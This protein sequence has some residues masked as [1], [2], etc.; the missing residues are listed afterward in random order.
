MIRSQFPG[1]TEMKNYLEWFPLVSCFSP[2]LLSP[3][4]CLSWGSSEPPL[5]WS[6]LSWACSVTPATRWPW[7]CLW[8]AP[9][10]LEKLL[11]Q[12]SSSC[13]GTTTMRTDK[14]VNRSSLIFS[15]IVFFLD[16]FRAFSTLSSSRLWPRRSLRLLCPPVRA[17]SWTGRV[18]RLSRGWSY[19]M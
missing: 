13:Q 18:G 12:D 9:T 15:F 16:R 11:Q 19:I 6:A 7:S 17:K 4:R 5:R 2:D 1:D 8:S 14:N 10:L 3:L